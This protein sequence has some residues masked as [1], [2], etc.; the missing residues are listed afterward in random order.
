[1]TW[2][3]NLDTT[4]RWHPRWRAGAEL[5]IDSPGML[6]L[7]SA[8][9]ESTPRAGLARCAGRIESHFGLDPSG[10]S[11]W[12]V[13]VERSAIWELAPDALDGVALQ[14]DAHGAGWHA[15][16]ALHDKFVVHRP[17][18]SA[19]RRMSG[20]ATV[21]GSRRPDALVLPGAVAVTGGLGP[22]LQPACTTA[23]GGRRQSE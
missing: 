2:R 13:G 5:E 8:A 14:A 7:E 9:I 17:L 18:S 11:S 10:S 20:D 23:T 6:G 22:Q 21:E 19:V 4:L 12:T 3:A 1:M 15:S 16:L